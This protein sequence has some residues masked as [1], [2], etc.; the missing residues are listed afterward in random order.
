MKSEETKKP[1]TVTRWV[2]SSTGGALTWG[3]R[4]G[5]AAVGSRRRGGGDGGLR[6]RGV[7]LVLDP[8]ETSGT[9]CRGDIGVLAHYWVVS[10]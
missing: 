4:R 8:S 1:A 9:R 10:A 5:G 2:R 7:V 6:R 3:D